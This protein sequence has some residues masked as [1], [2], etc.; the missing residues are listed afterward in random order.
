MRIAMNN[1]LIKYLKPALSFQDQ[2]EKLQAKGLIINNWP[3]ALQSLSNTNYYRLSA[4]C[5]P[6]KRSDTT[7][8]I[9][10]QFQDNV[11]FENVI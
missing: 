4:Y 1:P 11:T 6:F 5:L 7:G 2:L 10:E 3:S 9:T 8:N